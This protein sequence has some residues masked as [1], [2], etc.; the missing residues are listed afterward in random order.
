MAIGVW[1]KGRELAMLATQ[2]SFTFGRAATCDLSL[3]DEKHL[4]T[5]HIQFDRILNSA[6]ASLRGA[7]VSSGKNDV[8]VM[9]EVAEKEWVMGAGD[10]FN[11]GDTKYFALNE[12]MRHGRHRVMEILGIRQYEAVDDLLIAAVRDSTRHVLFVG[13]PGSDQDRLARVVHQCSHRRHNQ[14]Q[15]LEGPKLDAKAQK[16]IA[17][18]KDGTLLVPMHEKGKLD[19]RLVAALVDPRAS[20]R[21]V[22]CAKSQDK[23]GASFPQTFINDAKKIS[24]PPLRKRV[25]DIPELLDQWLVGRRSVVRFAA[26]RPEVREAIRAYT[27]PENIE[28]LRETADILAELAHVQSARQATT[29]QLTRGK[30]R[31]WMKKLGIKLKF[32]IVS[33]KAESQAR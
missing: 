1:G 3:P 20:L 26:L 12:E 24:I 31:G 28:E 25:D 30:V 11:V 14:Y 10:W 6:H 16:K 9:G 29:E 4:A 19:T 33:D 21:L 8:V 18:A 22:L 32:P 7:D 2:N 23:A 15:A 27:W 5:V 13:E 17:D